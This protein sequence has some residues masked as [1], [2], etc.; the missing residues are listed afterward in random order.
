MVPGLNDDQIHY[1]I[2]LDYLR[3][4]SEERVP[5]NAPKVLLLRH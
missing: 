3:I 4:L 1:V 5:R 2:L